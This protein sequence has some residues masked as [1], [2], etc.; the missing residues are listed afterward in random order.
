MPRGSRF[1]FGGRTF[2]E[3]RCSPAPLLLA[4]F[5]LATRKSVGRHN[6]LVLSSQ[7]EPHSAGCQ[8]ADQCYLLATRPGTYPPPVS[9]CQPTSLMCRLVATSIFAM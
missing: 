1:T 6:S 3:M 2:T 5:V 9:R 8:W 4:V 7:A